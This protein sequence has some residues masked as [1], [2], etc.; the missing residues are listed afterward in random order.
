MRPK[1]TV[2]IPTYNRANLVSSAVDSILCQTY[3]DFE[4]IVVDDGS[5]DNTK[6][7]L[8]SYGDKIHYIYQKNLEKSEARNTGIKLAKGEY[9]AFL[10]S[11]DIWFPDKL[12]RQVPVLDAAPKNV[13]LVHGYKQIVDNELK[14]LSGYAKQLRRLYRLAEEEKETYL[15]YLRSHCIFTST[16]LV[17]RT[18]LLEIGGYD[19]NIKDREDLDLYLR[20]LLKGYAFTFVKEPPLVRY[21][22][23]DEA[24]CNIEF[25]IAYLKVYQKHLG[26][27]ER[28]KDK[29]KKDKV[30][31]LLYQNIAQTYYRLGDFKESS[32]FWNKALKGS[33]LTLADVHFWKQ[34]LFNLYRN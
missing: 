33:W 26:L 24:T 3:D 17:R 23:G 27:C 16:I 22:L 1:V 13:V 12:A 10:D 19:V 21:R 29:R 31:R 9:V 2:I 6:K 14:P 28:I 8:E 4:L 5:T 34:G 20:F 25:D 7:V 18:A 30:K 32:V 15:S 11:D